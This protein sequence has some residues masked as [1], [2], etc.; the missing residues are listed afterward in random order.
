M[1]FCELR[2]LLVLVRIDE[3]GYF[4]GFHT[5]DCNGGY[6]VAQVIKAGTPHPKAP[7]LPCGD[8]RQ[9]S[10]RLGIPSLPELRNCC[11]PSVSDDASH[12]SERPIGDAARASAEQRHQ[13]GALRKGLCR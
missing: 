3:A 1:L 5:L 12:Q 13:G 7:R 11:K 10:C 8:S 2:N 9:S 4:D 6:G